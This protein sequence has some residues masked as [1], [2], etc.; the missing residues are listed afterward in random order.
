ME[1]S[2]EMLKEYSKQMVDDYNLQNQRYNDLLKEHK[3][4][5]FNYKRM[6]KNFGMI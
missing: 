3:K 5:L 2:Y 4:T 1:K 6:K